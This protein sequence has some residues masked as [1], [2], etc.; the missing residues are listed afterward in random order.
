MFCVARSI[1]VVGE[2]SDLLRKK[3]EK[4]QKGLC[5]RF[6]VALGVVGG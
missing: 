4:I 2:R 6:C 3:M 1:A 5:G